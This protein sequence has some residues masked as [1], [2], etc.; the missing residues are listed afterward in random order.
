M[1]LGRDHPRIR[2]E[3]RRC[4]TPTGKWARIIPA[5]AGSTSESISRG[6]G[7]GDH[8]RIRG[9]HPGGPHGDVESRRII[10][11]YAGSTL[12]TCRLILEFADHPRIRGEHGQN[13]GPLDG[14][15][16][17]SPHTRGARLLY[18]DTDSVI[19]IIPAYAGSTHPLG[20][21]SKPLPDHPRIRG[22]HSRPAPFE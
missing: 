20:S 19:R 11:A 6:P 3:H 1:R 13:A 10:P 5:Y 12:L 4:P 7:G 14:S 22:E 18:Y 21:P 17:S 16:G 2:G 9:E 15:Y 8:P